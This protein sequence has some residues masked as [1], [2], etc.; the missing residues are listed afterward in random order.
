[1]IPSRNGLFPSYPKLFKTK[2]SAK[3]LLGK[4][5]FIFM[6]INSLSQER[7]CTLPRFESES[8]K[9]SEMVLWKQ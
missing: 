4:R 7:F 1:M 8:Y 5:D 3:L 9:K 2:L 6:Q